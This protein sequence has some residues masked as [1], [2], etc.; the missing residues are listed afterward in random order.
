MVCTL[1]MSWNRDRWATV[2]AGLCAR[3]GILA[4]SEDA[5]EEAA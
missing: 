5:S 1:C 4:K 2:P 3:Y